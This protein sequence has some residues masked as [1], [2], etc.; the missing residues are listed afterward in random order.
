[1]CPE[2]SPL[3]WRLLHTQ[4]LPWAGVSIPQ[5]PAQTWG[6]PSSWGLLLLWLIG[7]EDGI[8]NLF[9]W[10][11]SVLCGFCESPHLA[12]LIVWKFVLNF[13][14]SGARCDIQMTQ[15]T[16]LLSASLWESVTST[17]Q[18]SQ[19]IYNCLVWYQQ[20]PWEPLKLLIYYANN[21]ADGTPSRFSGSGSGTQYSLEISGL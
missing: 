20:K 10:L 17:C 12:E 15:S 18:S 6:S 2:P 11:W 7:K 1:M 16:A 14:V 3:P 21:L 13:P 8:G 19:D 5:V 9:I 4:A